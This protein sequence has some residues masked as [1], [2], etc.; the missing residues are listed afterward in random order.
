MTKRGLILL[1]VLQIPVM[2]TPPSDLLRIVSDADS[3]SV[4]LYSSLPR[5]FSFFILLIPSLL[6]DGINDINIA[7]LI[8][9]MTILNA[10]CMSYLQESKNVTLFRQSA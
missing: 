9:K 7:I 6:I 5:C 8:Q 4:L 10:L 3:T 2:W 1:L